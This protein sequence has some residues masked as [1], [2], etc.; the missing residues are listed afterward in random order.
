MA[1]YL[2]CAD[3]RPP[4]REG[5]SVKGSSSLPNGTGQAPGAKLA[6]MDLSRSNTDGVSSTAGCL[7][8]PTPHLSAPV[9]NTTRCW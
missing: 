3:R 5:V 7:S 2:T 8:Y 4:C 6:F 9:C 1:G